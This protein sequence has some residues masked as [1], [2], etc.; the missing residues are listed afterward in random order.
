MGYGNDVP[1]ASSCTSENVE[2]AL[3]RPK[4]KVQGSS[5]RWVWGLHGNCSI[6]FVPSSQRTDR[7]ACLIGVFPYR[8]LQTRQT[9]KRDW[10]DLVAIHSA[11]VLLC[12]CSDALSELCAVQEP[13]R[14]R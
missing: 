3:V 1:G 6:D 4:R 12:S 5:V 10:S 2:S 11:G 8:R 7:L 9:G 13:R 14:H